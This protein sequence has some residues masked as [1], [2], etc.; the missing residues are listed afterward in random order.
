MILKALARDPSHSLRMTILLR[1]FSNATETLPPLRYNPLPGIVPLFPSPNFLH[2]RY[3][4]ALH[5]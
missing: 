5:P 4:S 1:E 3:T 2:P